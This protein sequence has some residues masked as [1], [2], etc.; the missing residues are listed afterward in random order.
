MQIQ[1]ISKWIHTH[2]WKILLFSVSI[3]AL[4]IYF[5]VM[6]D[7][8]NILWVRPCASKLIGHEWWVVLVCSAVILLYY[9]KVFVCEKRINFKRLITVFVFNIIYWYCFGID[10]WYYSSIILEN[11]ITVWSHILLVIPS[12]CE[13]IIAIKI[14]FV[15]KV[16]KELELEI[17]KVED[18]DDVYKRGDLYITTYNILET[19]YCMEGSFAISI[20][21]Q[22]GSGKTTFKNFIKKNYENNKD[23]SVI[24]FEPWK[25]DSVDGITKDFFTQLCSELSLY[26]PNISTNFDKYIDALLEEES[27]RIVKVLSKLLCEYSVHKLEIYNDIISKLKEARHKTVVFI[28]DLDR[29]ETAEIKEVLRLIRNTANF[30]YIQFIVVLD[31]Q[32]VCDRLMVDGINNPE[33]YLEKFFNTEIS[34]PKFE[35]R[36]LCDEIHT[37]ISETINKIWGVDKDD[38]RIKDMIYYRKNNNEYDYLRSLLI[39]QILFTIRDIIRFNNSF[40]L[41]SKAYNECGAHTEIDFRDL[42]FIEL[43]HYRFPKIY[44]ELRNNPLSLLESTS[45]NY[46]FKTVGKDNT[47]DVIKKLCRDN[48][49]T[50]LAEEILSYLFSFNNS[51]ISNLR[52][53]DKYFMY[54][55]DSKRLTVSEFLDLESKNEDEFG[56][57]VDRLYDSKYKTEFRGLLP[58]ILN[59]IVKIRD[60]GSDMFYIRVYK[61]IRLILT[62]SKIDVLKKEVSSIVMEHIKTSYHIDNQHLQAKLE[63]FNYIDSNYLYKDESNLIDF[64]FSILIIINLNTK[65]IRKD[66]EKVDIDIIR[67]F[68]SINYN[69]EYKSSELT[70]F[71]SVYNDDRRNNKSVNENILIIPIE[72]LTEIVFNYFAN[73]TEKLSDRGFTLFYN[74]LGIV[75]Q[76][77][78][79]ERALVLMRN[80]IRKKPIE[81][82]SHYICTGF[83]SNPECNVVY[84]EVYYR[85]IFGSNDGFE[86]FLNNIKGESDIVRKVKNYWQ[87]YKYN[88]YL[89]IEFRNQGVVEEKIDKCFESEVEQLN[90]LLQIKEKIDNKEV[91]NDELIS[92]FEKNNLYIKL[93]GKIQEKINNLL[94]A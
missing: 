64:F 2:I 31:K 44:S 54:R 15:T 63:L 36:I 33:L 66:I 11:N 51:S 59:Q 26:V 1:K 73:Y 60:N 53:Y 49:N 23:V 69:V 28:D 84:P 55:L 43:L 41:I 5:D 32:Y 75:E 89:A 9:F 62:K 38:I 14:K 25:S 7:Y 27:T 6:L 67:N 88:D 35:E 24:E 4:V 78:L 92:R 20:T 61:I 77:N 48:Q 94:K 87:L 68:L 45:N 46:V 40:Y 21:G 29:L 82:L 72:E 42:F 13:V 76:E 81:Y 30:P 47:N 57:E 18:V 74:F 79:R 8:I 39:P 83:S 58:D 19:C 80:E 93:R 50:K 86:K 34:L 17:E 10:R 65:F 37:R 70:K 16:D 52:N 22:W 3:I 12:L 91:I 90:E 71:I 56:N 85:D